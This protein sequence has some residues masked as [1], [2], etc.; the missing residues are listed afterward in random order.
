VGDPEV[1]CQARTS[2]NSNV[3][4]RVLSN[5]MGSSLFKPGAPMEAIES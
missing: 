2:T 5:M 3:H 4:Q 1:P